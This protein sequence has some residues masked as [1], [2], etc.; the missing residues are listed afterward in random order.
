MG[1]PEGTEREEDNANT[2]ACMEFSKIKEVS[3]YLWEW[4]WSEYIIYMYEDT[5]MKSLAYAISIY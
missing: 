1:G 4:L 3:Q 5:M 2:Y